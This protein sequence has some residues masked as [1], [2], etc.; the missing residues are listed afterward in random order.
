VP[1]LAGFWIAGVL[2]SAGAAYGAGALRRLLGN[3]LVRALS[4]ASA[5]LFVFFA[6]KVFVQGLRELH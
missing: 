6:V 3:K 1:F 4:L 2:W 5:A